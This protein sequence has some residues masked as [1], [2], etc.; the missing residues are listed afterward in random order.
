MGLITGDFLDSFGEINYSECQNSYLKLI[1]FLRDS[2][3]Q[4]YDFACVVLLVM[5]GFK[6]YDHIT[7]DY[8]VRFPK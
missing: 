8:V 4:W 5:S 2:K 6:K 1:H 3:W 7:N